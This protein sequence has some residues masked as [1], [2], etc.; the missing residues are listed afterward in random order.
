MICARTP[1]VMTLPVAVSVGGERADT[2]RLGSAPAP[3]GRGG[4]S[5][6]LLLIIDLRLARASGCRLEPA[7]P[8]RIVSRSPECK[9]GGC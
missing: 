5:D 8:K 4:T 3:G 2:S 7:L 6:L 9:R 1:V